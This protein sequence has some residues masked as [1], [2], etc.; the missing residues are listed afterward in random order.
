MTPA[1]FARSALR[2]D[3]DG[4]LWRSLDDAA[5]LSAV[6]ADGTRVALTYP[7]H[8]EIRG[9]PAFKLLAATSAEPGQQPPSRAAEQIMRAL[10]GSVD[11][12]SVGPSGLMAALWTKEGY[13]PWYRVV[14]WSGSRQATTPERVRIWGH[15]RWSLSG[16]LAV[17]AFCGIRRGIILV[18]PRDGATQWWSRPASASYRL[19]ALG[20][21]ASDAIAIRADADGSAWLVQARPGGA[22][23]E[24]GKLRAADKARPQIVRWNH[25]G[26][27]LEGLLAL[28]PGPGPHP[29]LVFLHGGP[30]AGLACGEHPDMSEWVS[31]GFA[32]FTPDFRSSGV[33]GRR[34]MRQA[35]YRRGLPNADP[36]A[37]EV[38]AGVDSLTS[39][40]IADP[41][42]L[43]LFGHSYGGY[44]AGRIVARDGRFRAAVCC[45]GVADLRL[46]DP[47]S[48]QMHA[49]WLGGDETG[50][51]HRWADASPVT[52]AQ[53]VRTPTLL[54]YAAGGNLTGQGQAWHDALTAAG[55]DNKLITVPGADHLFS[56]GP[57]QRELRQA[58]FGW[59]ERHR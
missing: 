37:G 4:V 20:P 39:R 52:R 42:A 1:V 34:R 59:L 36:E 30:V 17:T 24:L 31:A 2:R 49:S 50:Q 22:D 55:V 29:L 6:F 25:D 13:P 8:R 58:V 10:G 3:D 27:A 12:I 32:V 46:L 41:G 44:L 40:G 45:E 11:A 51:P 48:K 38:L 26:V 56:S 19:L 43:I 14:I 5:P 18:S 9:W 7:D 53:R 23:R 35:F 57:A 54:I 33:T 28:P 15:P 21:G 47:M 16:E